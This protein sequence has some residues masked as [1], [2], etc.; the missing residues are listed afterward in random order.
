MSLTKV[1]FIAAG[2]PGND[3]DY[4]AIPKV[5]AA[6][7]A[8][9]AG[10]LQGFKNRLI[11]GGFA[12][13]QRLVASN[14]DDTYC[15]DQWYVL[16]QTGAVAASQ[17]TNPETGAPYGVRLT[18]SQASAQRMGL[19]QI[20]ESAHCRDLRSVIS[21]LA[22]RVRLS[23]SDNIRYAVLEWTGTADAVT[24]DVVNNWTSTTYT[25]GNFFN[26]TTLNVLAVG[27]I[28]ATANTW[29][30][31]TALNATLGASAN[32]AIVM[33][34]T[35]NA[36]AQNVTLDLNRVQWEPGS[37]A[38]VFEA[39]PLCLELDL[40]EWYYCK[41]FALGT[42]PA[43]NVG[44]GTGEERIS[45]YE[46]GAALHVCSVRF[47]RRMRAA[48]TTTVYNPAAAN[49]QV[50]DITSNLD[51]SSTNA[52]NVSARGFTAAWLGN[53]STVLTTVWAFHWT[54]DAGL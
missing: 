14:T 53:A 27:Q 48:P 12:I 50:R 54:A 10:Q 16:T 7:D 21:T 31:L 8:A 39:R 5:N 26:S 23:T 49:A 18:Q 3:W 1:T 6:I 20:V 19:A 28:G 52:Q 45:A 17:L 38:T 13:N 44:A 34:W 36:V 2:D 35:E 40:C 30:D 11:N 37:V 42:A 22:G 25:A 46:S 29:R 9:N 32:N 51:G 4:D 15:L 24:S 47:P 41:S 43:Q 33:V